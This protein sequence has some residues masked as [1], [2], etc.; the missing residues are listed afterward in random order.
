MKIHF[1]NDHATINPNI[2]RTEAI[3]KSNLDQHSERENKKT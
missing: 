2:T 1:E 3:A